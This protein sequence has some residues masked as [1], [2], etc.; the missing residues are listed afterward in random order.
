[1]RVILVIIGKLIHKVRLHLPGASNYYV[2]Y[3]AS[4]GVDIGKGVII[5]EPSSVTIDSSRPWL[6][7]IGEYTKITHG[8]VILT[9]DYSLST[10]RRTYGL[11]IGEGQLTSIGNNCFIGA[12]S[13]VL[14]G[15]RIGNNVIVGAGSVVR[16]QIPDNVVIAGNPAKVICS[17]DEHYSSRLKKTKNEAIECAQRY[18]RVYGKLP[19]PKD[20]EGFKFLF[21]PRS[22]EA[23][24]QY[25]LSFQCNG[26]EPDEV[27]EAFFASSPIWKDFDEFLMECGLVSCQQKNEQNT[28]N[29]VIT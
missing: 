26:D 23:I 13:I 24:K 28:E 19:N 15:S 1:M 12:N 16:G 3:L 14:M 10:L 27:R 7:K 6:L 2:R 22:D 18:F 29:D 20:L 11:W 21:A 25:G 9:H 8:A 4:K 17:L 5:Y